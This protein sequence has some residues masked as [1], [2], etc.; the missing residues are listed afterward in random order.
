METKAKK[1]A[2]TIDAT[3]TWLSLVELY[4]QIY[5]EDG[6]TKKQRDAIKEHF[7]QCAKVADEFV[8]LLKKENQK[9]SDDLFNRVVEI[10]RPKFCGDTNIILDAKVKVTGVQGDDSYLNGL[11]GRSCNPFTRGYNTTGMIGI[12]LFPNQKLPAI[13]QDGCLN[14]DAGNIMFIE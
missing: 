1:P 11:A 6:S 9:R 4:L 12:K 5:L 14:I 10:A 13:V 8:A 3:P 7:I 2:G